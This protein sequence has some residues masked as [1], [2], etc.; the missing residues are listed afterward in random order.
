MHSSLF[1]SG[2]DVKFV[3]FA[4]RYV[5]PPLGTSAVR[6]LIVAVPA[7]LLSRSPGFE[8]RWIWYLSVTGVYL[9]LAGNLWLLRREYARR[10][11]PA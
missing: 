11:G 7:Y 9:Q 3:R 10:L 5:P 4:W 8:L 2:Y 6:L 1:G